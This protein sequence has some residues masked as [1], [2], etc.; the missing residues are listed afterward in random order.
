MMGGDDWAWG[1]DEYGRRAG[2]SHYKSKRMRE[3]DWL[4][5][6]LAKKEWARKRARKS[7]AQVDKIEHGDVYDRMLEDFLR[8][9]TDDIL[10][11]NTAS[12]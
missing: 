2:H 5:R 7:V 8:E 9:Q 12:K 3:R 11:G 4:R 10:Q 1:M 6:E